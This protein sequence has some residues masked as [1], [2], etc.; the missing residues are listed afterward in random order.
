M[1]KLVIGLGNP[2]SKYRLSR[3]N[4]G[5]MCLDAWAEARRKSFIMDELYQYMIL[6]DAIAI[7]PM[8]YMN[9]SGK[10]LKHALSRWSITDTMVVHDDLELEPTQLRIRNGG[11]DGGHNGLKSLFEVLAPSEIKRLRIG[12]GR[13]QIQAPDEYVLDD[14]T[15]DELNSY[16]RSMK[17]VIEFLN[18]Y[19]KY[20]FKQMLNEYSKWKKSYSGGKASG[21][22]SPKEELND[23][24]L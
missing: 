7:K 6:K 22:N 15:T 10:A 11:G 12:I 20:D 14:F 13:S 24:G 4:L 18:V 16:T 9:L 21:I 2:T 23:Q 8:T 5:F 17:L 1:M 19:E 3:H